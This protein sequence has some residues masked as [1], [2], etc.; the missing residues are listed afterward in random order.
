MSILHDNV[1]V[2]C[3]QFW[4]RQDFDQTFAWTEKICCTAVNKK[5]PT[6]RAILVHPVQ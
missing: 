4:R 3:L 1:T 2:Y 6:I 5:S